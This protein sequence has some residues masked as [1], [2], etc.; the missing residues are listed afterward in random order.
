MPSFV[1]N[2]MH[3]ETHHSE[4]ISHF[5]R[6]H[7]AEDSLLLTTSC[8]NYSNNHRLIKTVNF[9]KLVLAPKI[10]YIYIYM[11]YNKH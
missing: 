6:C 5:S 7:F 10:L 9:Y 8:R 11:A 1:S 2:K 3:F 4:G